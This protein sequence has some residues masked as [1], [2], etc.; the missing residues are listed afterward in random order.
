MSDGLNILYRFMNERGANLTF[1]VK[2]HEDWDY[3]MYDSVAEDELASMVI[4]P[5][6]WWVDDALN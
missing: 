5:N 6:D 4:D 2:G 1:I 3:E